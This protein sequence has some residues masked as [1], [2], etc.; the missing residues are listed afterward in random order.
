MLA[1]AE[2]PACRQVTTSLA[3]WCEDSRS[4][5]FDLVLPFPAPSRVE[6]GCPILH[7]HDTDGVLRY[8]LCALGRTQPAPVE[9][10]DSNR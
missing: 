7:S 5:T 3:A 10:I 9:V 1:C 4:S 6:G 2:V 8:G